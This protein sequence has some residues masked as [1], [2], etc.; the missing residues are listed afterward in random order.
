M[1]GSMPPTICQLRTAEMARLRDAMHTRWLMF[2][3]VISWSDFLCGA[4][5]HGL[6]KGS[7]PFGAAGDY[8]YIVFA[9]FWMGEPANE[10]PCGSFAAS[11]LTVHGIWPQYRVAQN[12]TAAGSHLWP[13][14]CNTSSSVVS[15][16]PRV[17]AKMLPYWKRVAR[18]YPA[19]SPGLQYT[20]LATHE[21]QRHGTCWSDDVNSLADSAATAALQER[22]FQQSLDLEQRFP[23]PA[24]LGEALRAGKGIA[25]KEMQK[26]FGGQDHVGLQCTAT[27]QLEMVSLC[28][29]KKLDRQVA[30]PASMLQESATNSCVVPSPMKEVTVA[31]PCSGSG[32]AAAR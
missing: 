23:T 24:L 17:S 21:W 27:G 7:Q 26:A 28:F 5:P 12:T 22:F 15:V 10:I 13:Q 29:D 20:D 30:C 19:G 18:S 2:L 31:F 25:L 6:S 4:A 8:D 11:N 9:R 1:R 3:I 14:F 32:G 16:L